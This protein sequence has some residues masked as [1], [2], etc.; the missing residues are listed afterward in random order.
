MECSGD[1]SRRRPQATAA[2]GLASSST[3]PRASQPSATSQSPS[4]NITYFNP[5]ATRLSRPKPAFLARAAENGRPMSS[6]TTST[7]ID[8]ASST[9]PSTEPE[10]T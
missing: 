2:L 1:S 9:L 7:P 6:S 5:G 4:R 3:R 8:R 10:S